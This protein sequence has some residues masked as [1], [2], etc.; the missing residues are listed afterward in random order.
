MSS[1]L[2]HHIRHNRLCT[3]GLYG[4]IQ[5]MLLL[6]VIIIIIKWN[7]L[8]VCGGNLIIPHL[9]MFE[10]YYLWTLMQK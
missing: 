2:H 4:A 7:L 3:Y 1:Q 10:I 5:M 6:F 9:S 8:P